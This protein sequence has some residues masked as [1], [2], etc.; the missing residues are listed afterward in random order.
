MD[1]AGS[2]FVIFVFV[3]IV[4]TVVFQ[5]LPRIFPRAREI[6]PAQ[7]TITYFQVIPI[8][9]IFAAL[10]WLFF[11][12]Y[13]QMH[14]GNDAYYTVQGWLHIIWLVYIFSN[15]IF[16]Y[17]ATVMVVPGYP[18]HQDEFLK[19]RNFVKRYEM[20]SKCSRIRSSGTHHCS[21]C[22]TCVEMM[23]HH[24]PFTNNCIGL[25]NY[26]YYY[27][28]LLQAVVGLG[29]ACYLA[30]FPFQKCMYHYGIKTI[31]DLLKYTHA[32]RS[33]YTYGKTEDHF[34]FAE[35]TK[36]HPAECEE[37]G[38]YSIL[39]APCVVIWFFMFL[40]FTFQTL[41]LLADMSI[42]DFYEVF[43][44][45]SSVCDF[46][47]SLK[48]SITKKKKSRFLLLIYNQRSSWWRFFLPNF[49]DVNVDGSLKDM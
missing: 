46:F 32:G 38:Q 12:T 17:L 10:I 42:V 19:N 48:L 9:F 6:L 7:S 18:Q 34:L 39:L 8:L 16:N 20:C 35:L 5:L 47:S 1:L 43:G 2:I 25:R 24:C 3:V 30:I 40:L 21:W 45:S 41:L 27:S 49:T 11:A 22:H 28:F 26:I 15:V 14:V 23:C 36:N 13:L 37:T 4:G 33:M 44:R 31:K 29:Y